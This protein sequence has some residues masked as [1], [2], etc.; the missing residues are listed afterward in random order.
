M[1]RLVAVALISLLLGYAIADEFG[2]FMGEAQVSLADMNVQAAKKKAT[3][4][5]LTQAVEEALTHV[6]PPEELERK[7]KEIA[8]HILA[9]PQRFVVSFSVLSSE[10]RQTNYFVSLEARILLDALRDAVRSL[11]VVNREETERAKLAVISYREVDGGYVVDTP[12]EGVLHERFVLTNQ[13]PADQEVTERLLGSSGFVAAVEKQEYKDLS[14][15]AE[16][17]GVRLVVLIALRDETAED[18]RAAECDQ[19]AHVVIVD[20]QAAK[21]VEEFHYRFPASGACGDLTAT[22]A[23]ELF[24]SIMDALTHSG[25]VGLTGHASIF[26]EVT[27]VSEYA[28]YQELQTLIRNQ[29][30]VQATNLFAFEPGGRVTF[31]VVYAGPM[32]SFAEE[33]QRVR[34]A[35]FKIK[36]NGREGNLLQFSL[37]Y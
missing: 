13:G 29:P 23:N 10:E 3:K 19:L 16:L 22:A 31:Q 11:T 32:H 33:M 7:K 15:L 37:E 24:T 35:R 12:M 9:D 28:D 27:G 1:K 25:L 17:E 4:M 26:V 21:K 34:G 14:R 2:I 18:R 6:A 20:A 8:R 30:H 5:A 36:Y